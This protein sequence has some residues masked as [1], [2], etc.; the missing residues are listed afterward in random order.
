VRGPVFF[1][2]LASERLPVFQ[3]IFVPTHTYVV[4]TKCIF[5]Y[6]KMHMDLSYLYKNA[7]GLKDKSDT[8]EVG[9]ISRRRR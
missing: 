6:I 9:N 8:G 2:D 5:I 7:H 3:Y 4:R 1:M